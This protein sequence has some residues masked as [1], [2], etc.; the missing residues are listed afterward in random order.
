VFSVYD[1]E[2]I[3]DDSSVS[4]EMFQLERRKYN[5]LKRSIKTHAKFIKQKRAVGHG[6]AKQRRVAVR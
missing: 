5:S 6:Y 3:R 2:V 1:G 4:P